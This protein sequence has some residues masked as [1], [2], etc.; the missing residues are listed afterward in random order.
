MPGRGLLVAH[1][2]PPDWL[3]EN[4]VSGLKTQWESDTCHGIFW[5]KAAGR[6][7]KLE[8]RIW[9]LNMRYFEVGSLA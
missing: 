2:L 8:K 9:L 3:V 6:W 5:R 1:V 7:S 4:H